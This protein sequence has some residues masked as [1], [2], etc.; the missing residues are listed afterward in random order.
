MWLQYSD[1]GMPKDK[2]KAFPGVDAREV[3]TIGFHN[4][5]L[6]YWL[7][8]SYDGNVSRRALVENLCVQRLL[9]E[10]DESNASTGAA[11]PGHSASS[12]AVASTWR[13]PLVVIAYDAEEGLSKPALDVDTG[14]LRPLMEYLR[15]RKEYVGPVFVE[16]PQ[17][18][19]SEG[20]LK[21]VLDGKGK[22]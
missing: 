5:Y 22:E 7:Q 1:D 12:A 13:G 17:E 15:L 2:M 16:Q 21:K 20:E 19:W 8:V 4:Q 9:G 11:G 18:R 10:A 6:S 3:N 14:A